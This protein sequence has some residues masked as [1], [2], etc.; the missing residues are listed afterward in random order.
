MLR[1]LALALV[2][3]GLIL[4]GPALAQSAPPDPK[5]WAAVTERAR[6]QTVY[7]YA[8]AGERHINDYIAWVGTE[9]ARR[10]GVKVEH[11]K[12]ADTAEAVTRV[13]AEKTAGRTEGGA[14]DL[15]WIN[16]PNFAAMKANGLLFGPWAEDL[17]NFRFVDVAGKPSVLNDFTVP[18]EGLEAPWSMAQ[19]VFF[20]D[21]ARLPGPPASARALLAWATANPGRFAYPDPSDY[22]GAT[23]LKQVLVEVVA[24]PAIL[25]KPVDEAAFVTVTAPLWAYLDALK[26]AL[27]RAGRAFPKNQAELRRLFADGETEIAFAFDPAA[28]SAAIASKELP[29][30]V[31]SFVFDGGTIGNASFVAIPFNAAHKEGAMVVADFLL[32][33]EAQARKQDP[34]VWGAFTVLDLARLPAEDRRRFEALDLGIATLPPE[35]LGRH[36]P[37]PHPS[38]MTRITGEW[39]RRY[40]A[41]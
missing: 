3:A 40:G 23:F 29:E 15:I 34:K 12:I 17:P 35:K 16:G 28:A 8:W 21:R 13:L 4:A 27:W 11:V 2:S 38:W 37:E 33:P 1:R 41:G 24:D 18:T 30:T 5:N 19:I 7:W 31:R 6:G 10:F 20:H 9:T 32:S 22:L 14:V 39:K 26:P 25:Q 36:L